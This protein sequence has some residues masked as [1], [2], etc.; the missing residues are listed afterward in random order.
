MLNTQNINMHEQHMKSLH[1][2]SRK[3][4][5]TRYFSKGALKTPRT[6]VYIYIYID[7]YTHIYTYTYYVYVICI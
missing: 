3:N 1:G 5:S 2:S 4:V 6:C 7:R